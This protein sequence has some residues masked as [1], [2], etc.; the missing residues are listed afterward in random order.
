[1]NVCPYLA[2]ALVM[3][4]LVACAPHTGPTRDLVV[5]ARGMGFVLDEREDVVNP[6]I[7]LHAGERVR[8]VL[9]NDAPGL[10][11]DLVIP[12]LDVTIEQIHAGDSRDVTFVVPDTPGRF[13]YRCRPHSGMMSGFVEITR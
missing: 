2:I 5:V 3:A 4:F 11:H 1:M 8:L 9:K 12:D 7:Q 10:L 13:E 6:V